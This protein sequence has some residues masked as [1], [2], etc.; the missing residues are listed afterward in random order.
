LEAIATLR[1]LKGAKFG[2]TR[3]TPGELRPAPAADPG[4]VVGL[5]HYDTGGLHE[6]PA[7][8]KRFMLGSAPPDPVPPGVQSIVLQGG[9]VSGCHC[10]L[11]RDAAGAIWLADPGSKNGTFLGSKRIKKGKPMQLHPGDVFT[12]AA[13]IHRLIAL[14]A[15]M[16]AGYPTLVDILGEPHQHVARSVNAS[17]SDFLIAACG[18]RHVLIAS[19]PNCEQHVLAGYLHTLLPFSERP[20]V[21]CPTVPV[22]PAAQDAL[23]RSASRSTL[24]L[25]LGDDDSRLP[26]N[27]VEPLFAPRSQIRV[28]ILASG[29]P[30]ADRAIGRAN[31]GQ[32]LH[33]WVPSLSWRPE[34]IHRLLDRMFKEHRSE[35]RVAAL[36]QQNQEVLRRHQW[37]DNFASLRQAAERLVAIHAHGSKLAAATALGMKPTTLYSWWDAMRFSKE[38]MDPR[39]SR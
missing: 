9:F 10:T 38:L 28:V 34:A 33:I 13:T 12:V 19:A 7:N 3:T 8:T 21:D 18:R 25:D 6:L 15:E 36:S 11:S 37:K 5:A 31:V 35:L 1:L 23:V 2:R 26:S 27:F 16:L 24:V 4:R 17:P 14:N 22:D 20:R 32:M 30:V 39:E 29:L